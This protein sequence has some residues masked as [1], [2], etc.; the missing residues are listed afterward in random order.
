MVPHL[1]LQ[2]VI[3]ASGFFGIV[4]GNPARR[5]DDPGA[6]LILNKSH[7]QESPGP[8]GSL[9]AFLKHEDLLTATFP[10]YGPNFDLYVN[11]GDAVKN[12]QEP[13]EKVFPSLSKFAVGSDERVLA[14]VR[15]YTDDG[16]SYVFIT[17]D[18]AEDHHLTEIFYLIHFSPTC[19]TH[20]RDHPVMHTRT[21][22]PIRCITH[23]HVG[24]LTKRDEFLWKS[25]D[26]F[27]DRAP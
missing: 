1:L 6:P 21:G 26:V 25:W 14:C 5:S 18:R 13:A 4:L 16:P 17:R 23:K 22:I 8:V 3:V 15:N 2:F 10:S 20:A 7:E 27:L 9:G 11:H 24:R 19:H 12:D